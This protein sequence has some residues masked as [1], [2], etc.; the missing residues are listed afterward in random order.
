[1]QTVKRQLLRNAIN[2]SDDR[3]V[4][5][6][7]KR[8]GISPTDLQRIIETSG[9]SIAAIAKE[10]ELERAALSASQGASTS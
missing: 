4:R 9:N 10:V 5:A 6:V 8:L 7:T 2:L 1:M 3:Q